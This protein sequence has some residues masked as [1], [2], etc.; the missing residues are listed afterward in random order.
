LFLK[1]IKAT[2]ES[3]FNQ[4]LPEKRITGDN[5]VI[6]NERDWT[7]ASQE[8][9]INVC[10]T[11]T[12]GVTG[13][14]L[15]TNPN[16]FSWNNGVGFSSDLE[17]PWEGAVNP[18]IHLVAVYMSAA[19]LSLVPAGAPDPAGTP[20]A[21]QMY[22]WQ[23]EVNYNVWV[24]WLDAQLVPLAEMHLWLY[25]VLTRD[26][27]AGVETRV[28]V[29]RQTLPKLD[30]ICSYSG[31]ITCPSGWASAIYPMMGTPGVVP[32]PDPANGAL[33]FSIWGAKPVGEVNKGYT[34][35]WTQVRS[36]DAYGREVALPNQDSTFVD[37][38]GTQPRGFPEDPNCGV[39]A[40]WGVLSI[41]YGAFLNKLLLTFWNY[42]ED[43]LAN[44]A[45][46]QAAWRN[47][48]Q[49]AHVM[50]AGADPATIIPIGNW[51]YNDG[52]F[53]GRSNSQKRNI[54][55]V[56][57]SDLRLAFQFVEHNEEFAKRLM[58]AFSKST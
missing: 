7:Y 51:I 54:L 35:P 28:L 40:M 3:V 45:G 56:V 10:L 13:S 50:G 57:R 21:P 23:T 5:T 53:A 2:L 31:V 1:F 39:S 27:G 49:Q 6:T 34:V 12:A 48:Y 15:K 41:Q 25:C 58:D 30:D 36:V 47:K 8:D 32:S 22:A 42:L 43:E 24:N 37:F 55:S 16:E 44:T 9:H 19:G 52:P 33:I 4:V 26:I 38:W 18:G 11:E 20:P 29:Y 17:P 46:G 14:W